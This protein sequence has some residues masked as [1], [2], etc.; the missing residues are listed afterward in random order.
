MNFGFDGVEETGFGVGVRLGEKPSFHSVLVGVEVAEY[1]REM[2]FATW[3]RMSDLDEDPRAFEPGQAYSGQDHLVVGVD[4]PLVELFLDLH[5]APNLS[6]GQ[7]L[8]EEPE[9]IFCYFVRLLD[10]Q[11]RR[12][13]GL[14]RAMS[15]KGLAKQQ[16]ASLRG[17]TFRLMEDR[18]FK[19]DSDFDLLLD[20]DQVHILRPSG[21]E[22]LGSFQRLIR[23]AVPGNVAGLRRS[24]PFVEVD[25]IEQYASQNMRAARL[26]A[27]IQRQPLDGITMDSLVEECATN[28]I[29]VVDAG[30]QLVVE[31]EAI[32]GF[33]ETLDRRRYT[34]NLVPN[35]RE[36]YLAPNRR[37]I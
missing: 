29:V 25:T 11:N 10:D 8:L 4:D 20:D 30:G 24:L 23:E 14:R 21:F 6:E 28:A 17:G 2:A 32:I 1:L 22:N 36:R 35:E 18:M 26:L 9:D 13:T 3:Q 19:L 34:V 12:L 37:R 31:A 15:F 7:D 33:L 16:L 27:S 5:T